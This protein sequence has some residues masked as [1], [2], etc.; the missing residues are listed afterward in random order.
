MTLYIN[1]FIK[2]SI[3]LLCL[4]LIPTTL[5]LTSPM[6]AELKI[7]HVSAAESRTSVRQDG[8]LLVC[9]YADK[10][11]QKILFEGAIMRSEFEAR[12][13]FLAKRQAI[14]FYCS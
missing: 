10:R 11:C 2:L 4:S 12:L 6:A 9:S 8:G 5:F 13:P 3:F 1:A 14:I 7:E